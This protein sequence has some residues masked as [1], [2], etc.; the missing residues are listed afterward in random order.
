M[1]RSAIDADG[2]ITDPGFVAAIA[3]VWADLAHQADDPSARAG[4]AH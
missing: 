3:D 2:M 4:E 1:D